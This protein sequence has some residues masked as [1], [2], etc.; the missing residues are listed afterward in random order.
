MNEDEFLKEAEEIDKE[1]QEEDHKGIIP[2]DNH[3]VI[4]VAIALVFL[5]VVWILY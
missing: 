4:L 3:F 5:M 2:V 1:I